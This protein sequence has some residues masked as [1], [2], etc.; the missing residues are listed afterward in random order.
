[1]WRRLLVALMQILP[2]RVIWRDDDSPYLL[3]G[4]VVGGRHERPRRLPFAIYLHRFMASDGAEELHNHPW[5]WALSLILSG[6]YVEE[7]LY[8]GWWPGAMLE[9]IRRKTY[10]PGRFN[11]IRANDFHRVDLRDGECWTIF[12]AGPRT[13]DWGFLRRGDLKTFIPWREFT[14]GK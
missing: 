9:G 2:M 12:L 8:R 14:G 13:Q 11:F 4:Y 3:R 5:K 7:R 10:K 6:G 1:M